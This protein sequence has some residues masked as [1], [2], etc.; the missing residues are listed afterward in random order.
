MGF[1]LA[2]LATAFLKP[3]HTSWL[4]EGGRGTRAVRGVVFGLPLP[5]CSCGVVPMYESLVRRGV[6]LSAGLAFL[7]ATPEL[8]VDA[9][10]LS[11]PLLGLPLTVARVLAAFGVA[12]LVA[13]LVSRVEPDR[14]ASRQAPVVSPSGPAEEGRLARGLHFGFVELVDHTLPWILAGL[15]LA[16]LAEPLLDHGL[17]ATVPSALQVP[18]AA[19]VGIPMY[20]CASGATPLAA[21]ALHKGL[22]TGAALTFLLAG[23]AT[24]VTTFG[25]LTKLHGRAL[26]TRFGLVLI[27]VATVVGWGVNLLDLGVPLTAH[28]GALLQEQTSWVSGGASVGLLFLTCASL[29]RQGVRGFVDQLLEPIHSH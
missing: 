26:A 18:L 17:I 29:W 6:P 25:I 24:N 15:V 7:I 27:V 21:I 22:S 11:A 5:I 4:A 1:L 20:V 2:G 28:P 10:L 14:G 3:A 9:V 8:G 13:I 19:L 23:P 12:V 16:A